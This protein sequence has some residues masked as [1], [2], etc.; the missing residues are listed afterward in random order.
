M[1]SEE[2]ADGLVQWPETRA[3]IAERL[4]PTALAV[5]EENAAKLREQLGLLGMQ[6]PEGTSR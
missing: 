5:A 3:L 4:G 6:V 2:V 1:A